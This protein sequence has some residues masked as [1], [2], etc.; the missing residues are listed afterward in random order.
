M[1]VSLEMDPAYHLAGDA[2]ADYAAAKAFTQ[3]FA[4]HLLSHAL[5]H[6][7][8]AL[9]INVPSDATPD[10]RCQLTHLSCR[11]HFVPTPPDRMNNR[12]RPGYKLMENPRQAEMD[13]DIQALLVGRVVTVTPLS[14]DLTSR[15][16]WNLMNP[17]LRGESPA[18]MDMVGLAAF[19][20][21]PPPDVR[22][23]SQLADWA[24]KGAA[25]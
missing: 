15:V 13:S 14:L 9:N 16:D 21:C 6:D 8:D 5:P 18:Y 23:Y 19:F 12:G 3:H 11:R 22:L 25:R 20:N 4:R 17:W 7:V 1:A 2:S 24:E 10:T